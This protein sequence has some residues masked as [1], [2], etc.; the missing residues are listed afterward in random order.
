MSNLDRLL[1]QQDSQRIEPQFVDDPP[2]N[3]HVQ[4]FT[5]YCLPVSG[6]GFVAQLGLLSEVYAAKKRVLNGRFSG[7]KDYEPDLVLASSGGN[8]ATYVAMGGDWSPE[9]IVRVTS[10]VRNE[11]FIRSWVPDELSFIPSWLVGTFNGSFYRQG[12]GCGPLFRKLFTSDTIKRVEVWTGT[13]DRDNRKAQFFCNLDPGMSAINPNYFNE[14]EFLSDS[15]PLKYLSGDLD[16]IAAASIASA[17]IPLLVTKQKLDG[18][19]YA[20]GGTM[21]ASPVTVM[22]SEI[23]RIVMGDNRIPE[24]RKIKV[25]RSGDIEATIPTVEGKVDVFEIDSHNNIVPPT[26]YK[27]APKHLRLIYFCSYQMDGPKGYTTQDSGLTPSALLEQIL[28][29]NILMDRKSAVDVL[30]RICG[31]NGSNVQYSNIHDMTTERLAKLLT[32]LDKHDHYVIAL[33][34]HGAPSISLNSFKSKDSLLQIAAARAAY[35]VHIWYYPGP[36]EV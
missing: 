28:H 6:G 18:V 3:G 26:V 34:P 33:Y 15:M 14:N 5:V 4:A 35:G 20:D 13:F 32:V 19:S 10:E 24:N 1:P 31:D 30:Y 29:S 23:Y 36:C 25:T 2:L 27:T 9:G 22:A 16:R 17:S 12:H 21:Y 8:V 7:S 11:M